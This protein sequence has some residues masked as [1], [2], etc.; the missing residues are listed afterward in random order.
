MNRKHSAC[1]HGV[2]ILEGEADQ[3]VN[4]TSKYIVTNQDRGYEGKGRGVVKIRTE[5][6]D[7]RSK[8]LP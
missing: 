3:Y 4:H 6:P 2:Y 1:P 5:G 8:T 7:L